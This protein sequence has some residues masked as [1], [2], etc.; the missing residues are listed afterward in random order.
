MTI[1]ER[2]ANR[3]VLLL[4]GPVG[5]FFR[6]L[7]CGL[8]AA[9]ATTLKVDL[10]AADAWYSRGIERVAFRGTLEEWPRYLDGLLS[11]FRPDA[12]FMFGDSRRYHVVARQ[13]AAEHGITCHCFEEGYL[14]PDYV[15]FELGGT[16]F[17][18]S[19]PRTPEF[20][21]RQELPPAPT[22][23]PVGNTFF[24]A[25]WYAMVYALV[26]AYFSGGFPSYQHH[27]RWEPWRQAGVWW[28]SFGRKFYYGWQ[29][30]GFQRWVASCKGGYFVAP[31]QVYDDF[32]VLNSRFADVKD[33]IREVVEAFARS[34]GPDVV[35][36]LKHH[37][38]DRGH[39]HYG[40]F[41]ESLESELGLQ[42]RI[43]Y[44][45]D[46]HLPKLLRGALGTVVINSTVGISS[47]YHGTPVK[48]LDDS[49]YLACTSSQDLD[50]FF[51]EPAPV[52]RT[53][54]S[55]YI[56][57]L[58]HGSQLNGTFYKMRFWTPS[59]QE[60]LRRLPGLENELSG[61]DWNVESAR[62]G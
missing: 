50:A 32:Q 5:P 24:H 9:G 8:E 47:L 3:R 33:F 22:P 1:F 35:L 18:S 14:R 59:A 15:T 57:W 60:R 29:Q 7:A 46:I 38:R 49:V 12:L 21:Q 26:L 39:R 28:R 31:L 20:F 27:R 2:F 44:V 40:R 48:C 30:R 25:A 37:P 19:I 55:R 13:K 42:G 10:N 11:E 6:T 17:H 62:N 58:K 43:C 56:R 36:V 34:A 52:S 16:N 61:Q 53:L 41:I 45:H 4:Q 51:A 54:V 23:E